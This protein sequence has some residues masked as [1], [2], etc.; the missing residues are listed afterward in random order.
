MKKVCRDHG[1]PSIFFPFVILG[2]VLFGH[3]NPYSNNVIRAVKSATV[4]VL[5][6]HGE[7]DGFVPISMAE[8]IFKNCSAEKYI[9]RFPEADHAIC[10][11]VDSE[12]Y[13]NA[14]VSFIKE[15]LN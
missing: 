4:P 8:E 12:A 7:K 6:L 2:A 1:V 14:T 11:M 9:Y 10:Y 3:F 13:E 5:I 15:H